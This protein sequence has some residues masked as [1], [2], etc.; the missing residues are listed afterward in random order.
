MGLR[1]YSEIVQDDNLK[2]DSYAVGTLSTPVGGWLGL[3]GGQ[4]G[5]G[6]EGII[7]LT[8]KQGYVTIGS[9]IEERLIEN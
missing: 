7:N 2:S 3:E 1:S 6:N 4:V 8:N 9:Q 5:L